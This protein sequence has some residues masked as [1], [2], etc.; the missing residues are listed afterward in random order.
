VNTTAAVLVESRQPLELAQLSIPALGPGQVLV[1]IAYSGVCHTQLL[2]VRGHRGNDP[3]LPHCLGHEGS[4]T[5]LEVGPGV[6]KVKPG[7]QAILS[8]IKGSG[9]DVHGPYYDWGGRTVNAGAITTFGHHAV[10]SE[11][12]LTPLPPDLPLRAAA[13]LGCALPTGVGA[14]VN[15]A[16]PHPGQSLAVFG[17]G[18]VGLCAVQAAALAGCSPVVAVDVNPAKLEVARQCGATHTVDAS[19]GDPVDAVRGICPGGADYAIEASGRP[20]VMA[21]ALQSVCDRG[22]AA[23]VIGNAHFGEQISV[24]PRQLNH[25]KRLLGTWGGDSQPDRDYPRFARLLVAGRLSVEPL[26]G[27][28]YALDAINDAL[29]DLEA[30]RVVRPLIDMSLG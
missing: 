20:A 4:G 24:D 7:D 3:Y 5:V 11:N 19:A 17:V 2:E 12:R 15:T 13:L 9:A 18:G 22:G 30:G 29:D 21:Q 23:V 6:T 25:G 8:W 27:K 10:L 28:V 14:V 1:A 16:Q 26:L